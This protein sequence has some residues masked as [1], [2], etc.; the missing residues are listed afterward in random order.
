[1]EATEA[2]MALLSL[3]A[4]GGLKR[5]SSTSGWWGT[6]HQQPCFHPR[7]VTSFQLLDKALSTFSDKFDLGERCGC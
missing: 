2:K 1:M 7:H 3:T 4:R 6:R 5:G